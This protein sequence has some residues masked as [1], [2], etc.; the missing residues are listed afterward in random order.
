MRSGLPRS[1]HRS[2]PLTVRLAQTLMRGVQTRQL[3]DA[4]R[5]DTCYVRHPSRASPLPQLNAS[6]VQWLFRATDRRAEVTVLF[7]SYSTYYKNSLKRPPAGRARHLAVTHIEYRGH[8][9][10]R[11]PA[12]YAPNPASQPRK[13]P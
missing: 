11:H 6:T 7:S 4:K 13:S 3:R 1:M 5:G 12:Q 10:E 9:R 2:R 8:I